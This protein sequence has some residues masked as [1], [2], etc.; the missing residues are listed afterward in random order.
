MKAD[1]NK[2]KNFQKAVKASEKN[3]VLNACPAL[4]FGVFTCLH[5][6]CRNFKMA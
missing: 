3:K 4:F 2:M 1:E 6:V 5:Y